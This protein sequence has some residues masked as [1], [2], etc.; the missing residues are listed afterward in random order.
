M[1]KPPRGKRVASRPNSARFASQYGPPDKVTE[2]GLFLHACEG[3]MKTRIRSEKLL[4]LERFLPKPPAPKKVTK[5]TPAGRARG[6][7]GYQRGG[8]GGGRG[9]GGFRG[10]RGGRGG[11]RVGGRGGMGL[12]V[13]TGLKIKTYFQ[14]SINKLCQANEL[15]P[16]MEKIHF[17]T[18]AS[19]YI[20]EKV[21]TSIVTKKTEL[22][23]NEE[24]KEE[25]NELYVDTQT[26]IS[27]Q[28]HN[29]AEVDTL[30]G[31]QNCILIPSYA[32]RVVN[33]NGYSE[34]LVRVHG[35]AYGT[36]Q[37]RKKKLV[38]GMARRV[39]GLNKDDEKSK[40][41]EDRISMFLTKNL[42]NQRYKVQIVSLAHPS[43]M[44]LDED[45]DKVDTNVDDDDDCDDD[46]DDDD[47]SS[48]LS[49]N[50]GNST[51]TNCQDLHPSISITSNTGHF[52]NIIRIPVEIVDEWVIKAQKEGNGDGNHVR[53][54]KLEALP[55]SEGR[56]HARPSYGTVSLIEDEGISVISDIDDTIK[57]TGVSSGPRIALSNTFL[58]EL[59][60]VPG[61][62][63][64]YMDWYNKAHLKFY[65]D[66]VK[67]LLEEPG[68]TKKKYIEKIFKDFPRRKFILI[69]DS[70]EYDME[71]Y[72]KIAST[73]PEQVLHV[74][75]RDVSSES[76]KKLS[77]S[78]TKRSRSFPFIS[79]RSSSNVPI[80]TKTMP[81][82]VDTSKC[83]NNSNIISDIDEMLHSPETLASVTP[84]TLLQKFYDKVETC[85]ALV[86]NSAFTLFKDSRELRENMIVNREFELLL[87]KQ[88]QRPS[89][90]NTHIDLI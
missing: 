18:K 89:R 79:T 14:S 80:R 43:H 74:F 7:G 56:R 78:S 44:E 1:N 58:Y 55:E 30:I 68:L 19:N 13:K 64:V 73:Y 51:L 24:V 29:A 71:I 27:F 90:Q 22:E 69:G 85:K 28:E 33:E 66:L 15:P 62:A 65:N 23:I 77:E 4:P 84:D 36:S 81:P 32:S 6:R 59:C 83:N 88:R 8:R 76:L 54:L 9:V 75:I 10:G 5:K 57:L 21:F 16:A 52:H 35:W 38:L 82:A 41:L 86:P 11:N 70:G 31:L 37:S 17:T 34:W 25:I 46:N 20:K 3:D 67:S 61:M 26:S 39:A 60:E 63:D 48:N 50:T 47:T 12:K 42:R 2:M 45:P 40:L 72:S 49:E 53:L 87:E